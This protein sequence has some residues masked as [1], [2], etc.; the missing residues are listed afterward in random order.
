MIRHI[1][2]KGGRIDRRYR[3]GGMHTTKSTGPLCGAETGTADLDRAC[4]E[5]TIRM[6]ATLV[7]RPTL[8]VHAT[9]AELCRACVAAM[10]V[11]WCPPSTGAEDSLMSTIGGMAT[12]KPKASGVNIPNSQRSTVQVLIRLP[13]DVRD[14]LDEL[15]ERWG[16]TVSG[17]V[18]KLVEDEKERGRAE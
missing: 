14:D 2:G 12:K 8:Q 18:G 16:V 11:S 17:A 1:H 3:M 13:P 7:T 15:A 6:A 10:G 5:A 9:A 4:A